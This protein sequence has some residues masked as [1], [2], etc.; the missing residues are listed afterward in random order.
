L[1]GAFGIANYSNVSI[2]VEGMKGKFS[3]SR[4]LKKQIEEV[5]K[6]ST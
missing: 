5:E 2:I 3:K 6:G 4:K 1:G